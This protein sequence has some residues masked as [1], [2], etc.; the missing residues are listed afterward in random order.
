[1]L[2]SFSISV[3]KEDGKKN[4]LKEQKLCLFLIEIQ[5]NHIKIQEVRK[6]KNEI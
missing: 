1:M 4:L 3:L 2:F 5:Q 6:V